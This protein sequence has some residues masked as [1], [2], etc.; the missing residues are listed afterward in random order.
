MFFV[1]EGMTEIKQF[2][3]KRG[4]TMI[5]IK[6][7]NPTGNS[8]RCRIYFMRE[9]KKQ[10]CFDVI[11]QNCFETWAPNNS[12]V[13]AR[14]YM[15]YK[16]DNFWKIFG[17]MY[18]QLDT[19]DRKLLCWQVMKLF[20]IK[21]FDQPI[22]N[23]EGFLYSDNPI[24]YGKFETN[25]FTRRFTGKAYKYPVT[26]SVFGG[27]DD[28]I[29]IKAAL[30]NMNMAQETGIFFCLDQFNWRK[31][32]RLRKL[33]KWH[34]SMTLQCPNPIDVNFNLAFIMKKIGWELF[35]QQLNIENT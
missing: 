8:E 12:K 2:G 24:I 20:T 34:Y 23:T 25:L 14:G 6:V 7:E 33:E 10:R 30:Y 13:K 35:F 3:P 27:Q 28:L 11:L 18:H 1:K 17:L 4:I 5:K 29:G 15:Q 31:K 32:E 26:L 19:A 22:R 21:T 9:D 16:T